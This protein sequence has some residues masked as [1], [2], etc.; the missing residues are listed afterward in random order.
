ML[1][2]EL[3]SSWTLTRKINGET[4][5]SRIENTISQWKSGT[6]MLLNMR[7]WSLNSTRFRT[8]SMD[9]RIQDVKKITSL[10]KSWLYAY[11][12]SKPEELVMYRP[13]SYRG[14][15][16]LNVKKKAWLA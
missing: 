15:G 6:F 8:H 4:L 13:P 11:Q 12:F 1:G 5:Q 2:V 16:I 10:V 14:L 9:I 3:R 7:R